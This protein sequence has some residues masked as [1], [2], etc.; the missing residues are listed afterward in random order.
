VTDSEV[1]ILKSANQVTDIFKLDEYQEAL[2]KMRSRG[3]LKIA[4]QAVMTNA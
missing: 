2:D 4:I 1:A 3:A